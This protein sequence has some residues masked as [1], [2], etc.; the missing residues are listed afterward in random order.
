MALLGL[1]L[2]VLEQQ[3]LEQAPLLRVVL[4]QALRRSPCEELLQLPPLAGQ[5]RGFALNRLLRHPQRV[6]LRRAQLEPWQSMAEVPVPR[7]RP[8]R[9]LLD[10]LGPR[11]RW[12]LRLRAWPQ[13]TSLLLPSWQ[14]PSWPQPF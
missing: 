12:L 5:P 3:V 14:A 1:T 10:R 7:I 13:P 4:E 8:Q 11:L 9:L 2:G 6:T